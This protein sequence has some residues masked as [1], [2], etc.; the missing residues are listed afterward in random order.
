MYKVTYCV[1]CDRSCTG[2]SCKPP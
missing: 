2:M 1:F